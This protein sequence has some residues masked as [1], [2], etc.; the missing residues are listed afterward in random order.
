VGTTYDAV[1]AISAQ[2]RL[3]FAGS[4][5][6]DIGFVALATLRHLTR[7]GPRTVSELAEVDRV[8]TQ[9]IS[10]RVRP[11]VQVGLVTRTVDA[12]DGRRTVVQAT[13]RGRRVVADAQAAT[14]RAMDHAIRRLPTAD[15][16]ALSA[17]LPALLQIAKHLEDEPK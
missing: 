14:K 11:L 6:A 12:R 17:A 1:G 7:H 15:Q 3:R 10:L 13:P 5:A 8:T 16:D 9:A 4:S 2:L